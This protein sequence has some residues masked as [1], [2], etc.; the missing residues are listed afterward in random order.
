MNITLDDSAA[1]FVLKAIQMEV[2]SEGYI[3]YCS[4]KE[5][6]LTEKGEE[7]LLTEFGGFN[8]KHI[9]KSDILSLIESYD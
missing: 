5:R 4:S 2:D 7:V 6:V 8:K 3:I 1:L 9:I